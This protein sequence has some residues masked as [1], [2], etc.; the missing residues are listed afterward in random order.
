MVMYFNLHDALLNVL[1]IVSGPAN[2]Y[3][4]CSLV[5]QFMWWLHQFGY[6]I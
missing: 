6:A 1:A 5:R 2:A 4:G 3:G